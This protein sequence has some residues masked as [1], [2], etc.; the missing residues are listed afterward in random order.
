MKKFRNILAA[1]SVF[2][3]GILTDGFNNKS[4]YK[5]MI[6]EVPGLKVIEKKIF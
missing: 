2:A 5:K 1:R 3:N 4:L 6:I